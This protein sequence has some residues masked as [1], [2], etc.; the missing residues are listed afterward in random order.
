MHRKGISQVITELVLAAVVILVIVIAFIVG[1][2]PQS[3]EDVQEYGNATLSL[4]DRIMGGEEK[5]AQAEQEAQFAT[6]FT[7][8]ERSFTACLAYSSTNCWCNLP[9]NPLFDTDFS[10][11]LEWFPEKQSFGMIPLVVGKE[12]SDQTFIFEGVSIS[13]IPAQL[14]K[15]YDTNEM[16]R[17][18]RK[19]IYVSAL[20]KP[21]S[22]SKAL[23]TVEHS[24]PSYST[25][26]LHYDTYTMDLEDM[27]YK[28]TLPSGETSLCF[29]EDREFTEFPLCT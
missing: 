20:P 9:R 6:V 10:I 12:D 5:R 24:T 13:P 29:A 3:F 11:S 21:S 22:L 8:L 27:I 17:M 14:C 1:K 15:V 26:T 2:I 4:F 7:S 25:F 16:K 19:P 28:H 18:Q 23:L